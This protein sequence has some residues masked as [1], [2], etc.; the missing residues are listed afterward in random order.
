MYLPVILTREFGVAGWVAFAVPNVLGAAALP[1]VLRTP[2]AS[3]RFVERHAPAMRWFSAI[4]IAFHAMFLAWLTPRV[5][6]SLGF[7]AGPAIRF[8]LA[9]GVAWALGVFGAGMALSRLAPTRWRALSPLAW[10]GSAALIGAALTMGP[11]QA[12]EAP[13]SRPVD[14]AF[15]APVMAFGFLLC[16]YL[17]L[18]FHRVRR[19]AREPLARASF[20]AGFGG[21]FLAMIAGTLLYSA[22]LSVRALSPFLLAHFS[23]Q[24]AFTIGAHAREIALQV[25][26]RARQ[27]TVTPAL[28]G[29]LC[30]LLPASAITAPLGLTGERVYLGFMGLYA[31]A[32]PAYVWINAS[33]GS[34]PID[35]GA[36][37]RRTLVWAGTVGLTAPML[38][39]GFVERQWFWLAPAAALCVLS[40]AGAGAF[41]RAKIAR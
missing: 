32:L 18:T 4:T 40:R 14:L 25:G 6:P 24:S 22:Q 23:L 20:V 16:P 2:E 28:A 11:A 3:E 8:Q 9:V 26:P 29:V 37:R 36:R 39:L 19:D 5:L 15:L 17:D 34:E 33:W 31:V 41:E 38:W 30:A 27:W 12:A 13:R 21:L 7:D 1:F 35:W 10:A